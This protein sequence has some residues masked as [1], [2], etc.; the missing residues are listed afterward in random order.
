MFFYGTKKT[1]ITD[2]DIAEWDFLVGFNVLT[3]LF[4]KASF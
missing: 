2:I 1:D 4:K 3:F